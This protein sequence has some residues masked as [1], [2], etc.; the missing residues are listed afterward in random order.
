MSRI[1]SQMTRVLIDGDILPIV[2]LSVPNHPPPGTSSVTNCLKGAL[3][4]VVLSLFT[5]LMPQCVFI[6]LL[7]V[8][9]CCSHRRSC[10]VYCTHSASSCSSEP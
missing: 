10:M 5:S 6:I 1:R 2:Q 9:S 3:C 4:I 7:V 8:T